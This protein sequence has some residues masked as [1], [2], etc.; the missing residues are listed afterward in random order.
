MPVAKFTTAAGAVTSEDATVVAVGTLEIVDQFGTSSAVFM[1]KWYGVFGVNPLTVTD[2]EVPAAAGVGVPVT[3]VADVKFAAVI[4][5]VEYR[6]SYSAAVPV[7]PSS[8]G[9]VQVNCTEVVVTVPTAR[10]AAAGAVVS[11]GTIG[12][13]LS[14]QDP[15]TRARTISGAAPSRAARHPF[16]LMSASIQSRVSAREPA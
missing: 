11:S 5:A 8:P 12:F 7:A 16:R 3:A 15:I 6:I 13:L 9:A 2:W 4:T 1:A 14:P 10:I